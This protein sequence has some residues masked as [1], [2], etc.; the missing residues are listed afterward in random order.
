MFE[1]GF[2]LINGI[3]MKGLI[4]DTFDF[5]STSHTKADLKERCWRIFTAPIIVHIQL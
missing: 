3:K 5:K 2:G 4:K 1:P